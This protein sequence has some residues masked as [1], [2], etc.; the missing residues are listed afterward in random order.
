MSRRLTAVLG[1]VAILGACVPL[2]Q[3][4]PP[5]TPQER[6]CDTFC[7]LIAHLECEGHEGSPGND[8]QFGT[9]DD[10]GCPQVCRDMLSGDIYTSDR[11]CLDTALTCRAAEDCVFDGG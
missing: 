9:D 6:A 7:E 11:P 5:P 2:P 10:V 1:A 4:A 3:P 8:E